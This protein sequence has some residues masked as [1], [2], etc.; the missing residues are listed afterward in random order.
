MSI[1]LGTSRLEKVKCPGCQVQGIRK[2]HLTIFFASSN[3]RSHLQLSMLPTY[4]LFGVNILHFENTLIL[5]TVGPDNP[6]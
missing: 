5:Q 2:S 6:V 1:G 3:S 4:D